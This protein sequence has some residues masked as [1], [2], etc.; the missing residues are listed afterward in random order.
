MG[1]VGI[2]IRPAIMGVKSQ[3]RVTRKATAQAELRPTCAGDAD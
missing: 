3:G 2:P 1:A